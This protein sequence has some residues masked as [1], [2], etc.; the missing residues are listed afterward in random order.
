ML[1]TYGV[2]MKE[3][4]IVQGNFGSLAALKKQL[5]KNEVKVVDFDGKTLTTEHAVFTMIDQEIIRESL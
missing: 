1:H 3:D 5:E 4:V 2:V